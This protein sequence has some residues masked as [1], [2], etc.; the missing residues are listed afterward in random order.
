M[1]NQ[2]LRGTLSAPG[3]LRVVRACFDKLEDPVS[4][5]RFSL[6]DCLMSGLAVFG[7]KYP[8]LLR[9]DRDARTD[10]TVRANLKSLYAIERAPCDTALR[11]RLDEVD[12]RELRDVFKRV[13]AQLQRG[14]GLA[15]FT[16]LNGHYLLSVDGTGY[17]SSSSVHCEH[18]CEKHHKDGRVTYD[19]QMLGA[20]VVCCIPR[21]FVTDFSVYS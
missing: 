11:E 7:L 15:G 6:S 16:W 1:A 3:L 17:F 8:S 2:R 4:G 21:S 19:H 18:C 9:F 12:P 5:R 10:E 14:K 20:V 13:F